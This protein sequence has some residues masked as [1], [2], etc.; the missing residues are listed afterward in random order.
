MTSTPGEWTEPKSV[1]FSQHVV[2]TPFQYDSEDIRAATE[3]ECAARMERLL[4]IKPA[5]ATW[6][7]R[8]AEEHPS[9][10]DPEATVKIPERWVCTVEV[11]Q[12]L[13]WP[14]ATEEKP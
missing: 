13:D 9:T 4:G 8:P 10:L 2:I 7:H 14:E 1:A 6:E 3:R 12:R 11:L 5:K